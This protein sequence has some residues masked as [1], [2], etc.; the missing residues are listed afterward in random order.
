M[1]GREQIR[2]C[3]GLGDGAGV[4]DRR[5]QGLFGSGTILHLD[6][7]S[8]YVC[9]NLGHCVLKR[10]DFVVLKTNNNFKASKLK[11]RLRK[12]P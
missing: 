11:I 1:I 9:G 4:D 3:Q 7:D 8:A 12:K 5:A 6:C 10:K 2:G